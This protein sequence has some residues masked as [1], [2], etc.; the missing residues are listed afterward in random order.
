MALNKAYEGSEVVTGRKPKTNKLAQTLAFAAALMGGTHA[1]SMPSRAD[2]L[3]REQV[4][5]T[6]MQIVGRASWFQTG[7]KVLQYTELD[8]LHWLLFERGERLYSVS[9]ATPEG[10]LTATPVQATGLPTGGTSTSKV[11][12]VVINN[13]GD[14]YV[15]L[16]GT[17]TKTADISAAGGSLSF[18]NIADYNPPVIGRFTSADLSVN[19][20]RLY[21][22]SSNSVQYISNPGGSNPDIV[23][24]KSNN[25]FDDTGLPCID[26]TGGASLEFQY[27]GADTDNPGQPDGDGNGLV[28]VGGKT[29]RNW[30]PTVQNRTMQSVPNFIIRNCSNSPDSTVTFFNGYDALDTS[31]YPDGIYL[32]KYVPPATP[33]CGD[34]TCNNGETAANCENDCPAV[35][36]DGLE[37]HTEGC[38]DGNTDTEMCD[39]GAIA[40]Q[41]CDTTCQQVDGVLTGYCGDNVIQVSYGEQCDDG[42]TGS[43]TCDTN[44]NE[45]IIEPTDTSGGDAD[46]VSDTGTTSPDTVSGDTSGGDT[47]SDNDSSEVITPESLYACGS[48]L[49]TQSEY[50]QQCKDVPSCAAS[51]QTVEE[52]GCVDLDVDLSESER[53]LG[54]TGNHKFLFQCPDFSSSGNQ[55]GYTVYLRADGPGPISIDF[56][57]EGHVDP[58]TYTF[59]NKSG[60]YIDGYCE[61]GMEASSQVI[62][63]G[64]N[65][66]TA[67]RLKQHGQRFSTKNRGAV[68]SADGS[69]FES[70]TLPPN[71]DGDVIYSVAAYQSELKIS[72]NDMIDIFNITPDGQEWI[73]NI[74]QLTKDLYQPGIPDDIEVNSDVPITPVDGYVETLDADD[75]I[76]E[77]E[78][79]M[80]NPEDCACSSVRLGNTNVPVEMLPYFI[81]L[82]A[83]LRAARRRKK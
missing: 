75:L 7:D 70:M 31:T 63:E 66:Y 46:V 37:T 49:L 36:G 80:N 5:S 21:K 51:C 18:S 1:V 24:V 34:G 60:D 82:L 6:D 78:S 3:N 9:A 40:C 20:N 64:N 26:T 47:G 25:R 11:E 71:V 53:V 43:A 19:D 52:A 28:N 29:W 42:P 54:I 23:D 73:I 13:S 65:Y 41:V 38:D 48:R 68:N 35:C 27:G 67:V 77:A 58:A 61:M 10:L 4:E 8:G 50:D 16:G 44:C 2:A 74:T 33:F 55:V 15:D 76:S 45:I 83:A 72:I 69:D 17:F 57:K 22:S 14:N 59:R 12:A 32:L 62:C 30:Q 79:Q 81:G 39:Y 56:S